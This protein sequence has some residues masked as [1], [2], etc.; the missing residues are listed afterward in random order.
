MSR[1]L[2]LLLIA[3]FNCKPLSGELL[4]L[5]SFVTMS[6]PSSRHQS[7]PSDRLENI[8]KNC[9]S[10]FNLCQKIIRQARATQNVPDNTNTTSA[11]ATSDADISLESLPASLS[12]E[13]LENINSLSREIAVLKSMFTSKDDSPQSLRVT[14]Q[15][16][17]KS[18][19]DVISM[20]DSHTPLKSD[21]E[22]VGSKRKRPTEAMDVDEEDDPSSTTADCECFYLF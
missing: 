18:S 2:H 1:A 19:T 5:C 3:Q 22:V 13:L 8:Q 7:I 20:S 16:N 9:E 14:S 11:S 12:G 17:E 10:T 21:G 6:S 15:T 4:F